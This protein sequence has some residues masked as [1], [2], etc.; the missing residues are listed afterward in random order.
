MSVASAVVEFPE[1][2][3]EAVLRS[4]ALIPEISVYGIKGNQLI[5]VIEGDDTET[6]N[7]A[8]LKVQAVESVT[9][10]SPVFSANEP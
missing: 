9:G 3:G 8:I 5:I 10:V 7:A 4:L 6:I 2:Q 1:N